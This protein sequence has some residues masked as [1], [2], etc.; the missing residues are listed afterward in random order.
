[1]SIW[2][3]LGLGLMCKN[4]YGWFGVKTLVIGLIGF[5]IY[6]FYSRRNGKIFLTTENRP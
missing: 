2:A 3:L 5:W 4:V 1:M 6:S